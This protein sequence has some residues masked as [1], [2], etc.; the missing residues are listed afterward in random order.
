MISAAEQFA[1]M[2]GRASKRGRR[3]LKWLSAADRDDV[4]GAAILSCWE[5]RESYD[6][7]KQSLD[8]WFSEHL[9]LAR[10][11]FKKQPRHIS[12]EKL[13]E[14]IAPEDTERA[15]E[16][17]QAAAEL[18]AS[19]TDVERQVA[20]LIGQGYSIRDIRTMVSAPA[21]VTRRMFA[22]LRRLNDLL[23]APQYIAPPRA[24]PRD[25]DELA[26]IDHEIERMLRRPAT[27]RADCPICWRCAYFMGLLPTNYQPAKIADKDVECAVHATERDKI[28]IAKGET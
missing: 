26:P 7:A 24:K 25:S 28:R 8:D 9:K 3:Y 11:Q 1:I 18:E 19:L 12:T 13:A 23:P 22:K 17:Q 21:S 5:A 27:E 2:L 10:R 16:T 4:I 20:A 6:P 14:L 15:I